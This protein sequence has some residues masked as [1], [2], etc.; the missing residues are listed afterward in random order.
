M[1]WIL[2]L[3]T[4]TWVTR[5]PGQD[6]YSVGSKEMYLVVLIGISCRRVHIYEEISLPVCFIHDWSLVRKLCLLIHIR[7]S[8]IA[9][10]PKILSTFS[11]H[12]VMQHL[13]L[14]KSNIHTFRLG[15]LTNHW[16]PTLSY[17][18]ILAT[19]LLRR[20]YCAC[21]CATTITSTES[22]N[23]KCTSKNPPKHVLPHHHLLYFNKVSE[24][25]ITNLIQ[26]YRREPSTFKSHQ[27]LHVWT[28]LLISHHRSIFRW[29]AAV[30]ASA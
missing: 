15:Q 25:L 20:I 29:F 26:T 18:N 10:I 3:Y 22:P 24:L 6:T 13:G 12:V 14:L 16:V 23:L 27:C 8:S 30:N 2:Q 4:L 9:W 21:A 28:S 11:R 7:G 1:W 17:G 5:V 19:H